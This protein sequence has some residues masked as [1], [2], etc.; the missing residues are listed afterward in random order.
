MMVFVVKVPVQGTPK[1]DHLSDKFA[2]RAADSS[3]CVN[4]NFTYSRWPRRS[5][6]FL[7]TPLR[8][9]GKV[10]SSSSGGV[11]SPAAGITAKKS[12]LGVTGLSGL[13]PAGSS[14][15]GSRVGSKTPRPGLNTLIDPGLSA[16]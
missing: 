14:F 12:F 5:G 10:I 7:N 4:R 11:I 1:R 8:S 9:T 13:T 2:L 6:Y 15:I 16:V 3:R